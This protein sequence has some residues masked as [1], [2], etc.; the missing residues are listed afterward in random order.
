MNYL[1]GVQQK[2]GL[3]PDGV[4][5]AITCAKLRDANKLT[6]FQAAHLLGQM[7]HESG[8][9]TAGVENTNYDYDGLCKYFKYD[10]DTNHDR[11][12]SPTEL[13]VAQMLAGKPVQIANFVY[14]NQNGNGDVNSGDGW[15]YR[16][17]GGIM[18]TGRANYLAF[19]KW[20]GDMSIMDN[21]DLIA[22]KY[23]FESAL[24]FFSVYKNIFPICKDVSL[25]TIKA[26]TQI[27]NG[28][29]NNFQDRVNWTLYFYKLLTQPA[30]T[31]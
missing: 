25:A 14:A 24:W 10:L 13:K 6:N 21:P 3:K 26:V 2:Y 11:V 29:Q 9:F 1:I 4:I 5:G 12:L 15:K 28:G 8:K 30:I 16:G 19:A 23:Y 27:V 7:Y 18:L 22:T 20:I 31:V 17:R